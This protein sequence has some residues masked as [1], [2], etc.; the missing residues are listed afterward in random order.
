MK[1]KA[2]S[3]LVRK[4]LLWPGIIIFSVS[5]L[6]LLVKPIKKKWEPESYE[7]NSPATKQFLSKKSF[8]MRQK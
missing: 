1:R 2:N 8:K 5:M 7:S 6:L 3:A 4:F